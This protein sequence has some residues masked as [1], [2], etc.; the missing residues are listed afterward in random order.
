MS[1]TALYQELLSS[2][3]YCQALKHALEILMQCSV[4]Q[5][6]RLESLEETIQVYERR[7]GKLV[8]ADNSAPLSHRGDNKVRSVISRSRT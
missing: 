7:Y 4:K 8:S 5:A 6:D 3:K 1:Y 2:R